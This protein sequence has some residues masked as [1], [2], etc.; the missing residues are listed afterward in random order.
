MPAHLP[1]HLQSSHLHS[2]PVLQAAQHLQS[3]A[4]QAHL[5]QA[6]D[7]PQSQAFDALQ[8]H[9]LPSHFAQHL[10]SS[11]LHSPPVLQAAQHLQS[12]ALQAHLP[13]APV[14]PQS[15]AF[16]AEQQSAA[17]APALNAKTAA[18]QNDKTF[19]KLILLDSYN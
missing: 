8:P 5:P 7:A 3:P 14:A 13:Q 18:Q 4:L 10:Q 9:C 17:N 6:Q 2:P 16:F 12:P 11:H 19:F 15:Q 1:Q